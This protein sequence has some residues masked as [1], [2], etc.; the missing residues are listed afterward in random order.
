MGP[1]LGRWQQRAALAG[2]PIGI[3]AID[4]RLVQARIEA[5]EAAP[6]GIG[7]FC[8]EAVEKPRFLLALAE[9]ADRTEA[10]DADI[11]GAGVAQEPAVREDLTHLGALEADARSLLDIASEMT[12]G[13]GGVEI[14]LTL[15]EDK[16]VRH[17]IRAA[18]G[19]DG[20]KVGKRS[21]LEHADR[22]LGT[23]LLVLAADAALAHRPSPIC[24]Q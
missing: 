24:P 10:D 20:G 21:A 16:E 12:R 4:R 22:V 13:G 8:Q 2:D 5:L 11:T 9:D 18:V 19:A 15:G 23:H 17:H 6:R 1:L 7:V 14:E 3:D